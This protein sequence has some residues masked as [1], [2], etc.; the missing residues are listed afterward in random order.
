MIVIK[1]NGKTV[2]NSF[3]L[4]SENI[5]IQGVIGP[6]IVLLNS[7]ILYI[8]QKTIPIEAIQAVKTLP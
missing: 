6:Y 2:K 5:E 4:I 1:I 8:A 3:L 7:Q